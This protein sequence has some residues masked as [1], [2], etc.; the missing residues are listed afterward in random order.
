M[1]KCKKCSTKKAFRFGVCKECFYPN[2]CA[3]CT[4]LTLK[5]ECG[6]HFINTPTTNRFMDDKQ[7]VSET[8][9]EV[10]QQ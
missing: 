10:E 1:V 9:F 3:F 4:E 2:Y 5:A 7:F 6:G 8:L